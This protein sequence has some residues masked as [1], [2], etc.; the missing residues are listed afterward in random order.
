M[1][2]FD[3]RGCEHFLDPEHRLGLHQLC[4]KAIL[5][6]TVCSKCYTINSNAVF[7]IGVAADTIRTN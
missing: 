7:N 6:T 1:Q 2:T 4:R 5:Q 3:L